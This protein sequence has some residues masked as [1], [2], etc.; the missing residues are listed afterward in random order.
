MTSLTLSF[1]IY[2][3]KIPPTYSF[4]SSLIKIQFTESDRTGGESQ[5]PSLSIVNW[6]KLL[7]QALPQVPQL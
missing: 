7:H 5:I 6:G 1:F 3:S 4:Y 2:V